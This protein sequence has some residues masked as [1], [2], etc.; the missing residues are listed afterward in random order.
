M[1]MPTFEDLSN[2]QELLYLT[3]PLDGSVL[4]TGPPGTGKT[5]M[6][7]YR[8]ESIIRKGK[9]VKVLMFNSVLKK[10]SA[11]SFP[12]HSVA[13]SVSTWHT[14]FS[15]WWRKNFH[16]NPPMERGSRYDH[17]WDEAMIRLMRRAPAGFREFG[18]IILDEGQDFPKKFYDSINFVM[19]SDATDR[20]SRNSTTVF[21]DENQRLRERNSTIAEIRS[22]LGISNGREFKLTRN[23]RNTF[24]IA[25]LAA[26]FQVGLQTG[27]AEMPE[28][29][30]G[31]LPALLQCRSVGAS[32]DYI[33]RFARQNDDLTIGVFTDNQPSQRSIFD[34][35]RRCLDDTN[36]K[37]QRYTSNGGPYFGRSENL[38][39]TG[40]GTVTVL[41]L[42]SCKGLE[43]D[44][45][46]IPE[47]QNFRIDPAAIDG[48][49]MQMYVMVSRARSQLY[50][51]CSGLE[52]GDHP[53]LNLIPRPSDGILEYRSL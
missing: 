22:A 45:V 51:M 11:G 21:A 32:M 5:V 40:N 30:N 13:E 53:V 20:N 12:N 28:G 29:N 41:C 16:Q 10:F 46:F 48:F 17:D 4:V 1:R 33:A 37:V 3:A 14:W 36:V 18:H 43:F 7:F 25:R 2:E 26:S 34:H 52:N 15:E 39:F 47:L 9:T 50:L 19:N 35:L 31:P 42:Q 44:V 6:A 38:D 24:Q 27:V 8:A 49:R 23:Y